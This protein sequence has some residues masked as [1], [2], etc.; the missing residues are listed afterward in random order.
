[1]IYFET[2]ETLLVNNF[3]TDNEQPFE[4]RIKPF[5][6]KVCKIGLNKSFFTITSYVLGVVTLPRYFNILIVLNLIN[7]TLS[8]I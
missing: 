7:L 2:F 4:G 6:G 1:L 3:L 8:I 5:E